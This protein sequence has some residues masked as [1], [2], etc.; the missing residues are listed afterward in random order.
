MVKT[1]LINDGGS[2]KQTT[3]TEVKNSP[4]HQA[5]VQIKKAQPV[6]KKISSKV[7]VTPNV[8]STVPQVNAVTVA[9]PQRGTPATVDTRGIQTQYSQANNGRLQAQTVSN[10]VNEQIKRKQIQ[11][12]FQKDITTWREAQEADW[13]QKRNAARNAI[14]AE[15]ELGITDP[16][17]YSEQTRSA[18]QAYQEVNAKRNPN[19]PFA[20]TQ[21]SSDDPLKGAP[22]YWAQKAIA[23]GEQAVSGIASFL[24]D[25]SHLVRRAKE[26]DELIRQGVPTGNEPVKHGNDSVTGLLEKYDEEYLKNPRGLPGLDEDAERRI[27]EFDVKSGSAASTVGDISGTIGH[28]AP[29]IFANMVIPG[30]GMGLLFMSAAGSAATEALQHGASIDKAYAYGVLSGTTEVLTEKMFE[31]VP[32]GKQYKSVEE[33]VDKVINSIAG[34][35]TARGILNYVINGVGEGAEEYLSEVVGAYTR[36]IWDEAAREEGFFETFGNVQ[37]SAIEAAY[38][39][40]LVGMFM[41]VAQ[42]TPGVSYQQDVER[43]ANALDDS[44]LMD[45]HNPNGSI[46]EQVYKMYDAALARDASIDETV[47]LLKG[48]E[49]AEE[50]QTIY[51]QL[52]DEHSAMQEMLQNLRIGDPAV[53]TSY[54]GNPILRAQIDPNTAEGALAN[55][56]TAL[57]ERFGR[58]IE[59]AESLPYE[60]N[61][62]WL[63]NTIL[64]PQRLLSDEGAVTKYLMHEMTHSAFG[65]KS[66]SQYINTANQNLKDLLGDEEYE[67]RKNETAQLYA[68]EYGG[69]RDL[70]VLMNDKE[71]MS[72]IDE[73][74]AAQYS[75]VLFN[76]PEA[77]ERLVK[78]SRTVAEKIWDTLK[79]MVRKLSG[80]EDPI[81]A[82]EV[83]AVRNAERLFASALSETRSIT[84]K[85]IKWSNLFL[86]DRISRFQRDPYWSYR[87]MTSDIED[88]EMERE[89]IASGVFD[90]TEA[91]KFIDNVNKLLDLIQKKWKEG[92]YF[93]D[94]HEEGG[95]KDRI[96]HPFKQNSD[97]LYKVSMDFSTL[98][99]KRIVTQAIIERLNLA[100][101]MALDAKTQFAIEELLRRYQKELN[102]FQ[103]A[104]ALCYVESARLKSPKVIN[105][106]IAD[107]RSAMISYYGNKHGTNQKAVVNEAQA[108]LKTWIGLDASVNKDTWADKLKGLN[109][110]QLRG[111]LSF[112]PEEKFDRIFDR[113]RPFD[114]KG[115]TTPAKMKTFWSD[116][117]EETRQ[118]LAD[119]LTE[120]QQAEVEAAEQLAKDNLEYFLTAN[121]QATLKREHPDIYD[122][123]TTKVRNA[124]KSKA[125]ET[126]V[127][128]YF[129]DTAGWATPAL[130]DK[131][132]KEN[133]LRTQS[134]SDFQLEHLLDNITA[135][136][137]LA[138][139]HAKMHGY[140]KVP[141]FVMVLGR[142]GMMINMS[143]IPEGQ[144]GFD[145]NGNLAY[146]STEGMDIGVASDLRGRYPQTAGTICIG[147]NNDQVLALMGEDNIDYIIPYHISG[148][149]AHMRAM[150]DINKWKNYQNYQFERPIKKP[151][152]AAKNA[153]DF[154]DWF[155]TEYYNDPRAS[156]DAKQIMWEAQDR[157][158][159]LCAERGLIPKFEMF[160][161]N[162]GDGTWSVPEGPDGPLNYWKLLI[163]RKMI[164][165]HEDGTSELIEQKAV[166][167]DFVWEDEVDENGNVI[168][169]LYSIVKEA[170]DPNTEETIDM[171]TNYVENA[172]AKGIVRDLSENAPGVREAI[173]MFNMTHTEEAQEE[174]DG[175][176][177]A[178][179]PQEKVLPAAMFSLPSE[180][181]NSYADIP[182]AVEG[183][184]GYHAGNLGKA[185]SRGQQG[186]YR[187]T[188]H[189][190]TGTYFVGNPQ[191]LRYGYESRPVETV[192]FSNYNLFAPQNSNDA[193]TLHE[194]LK[195]LDGGYGAREQI[196]PARIQD[197]LTR[198]NENAWGRDYGS[199]EDTI[200][201]EDGRNFDNA[202]NI[203]HDAREIMGDA[204]QDVLD[205]ASEWDGNE[206]SMDMSDF[207]LAEYPEVI[208]SILSKLD[209]DS[210]NS[211][212]RFYDDKFIVDDM[213]RR[214]ADI[215]RM[216]GVDPETVRLNARESDYD[217]NGRDPWRSDSR[218][219]QFMKN[220]GY[221]GIDTRALPDFDNTR[222]GSVIYDLKGR[223]LE[224]KN[225]NGPRFALAQDNPYSYENLIKKD[226]VKV[227]RTKSI[228]S[229]MTDGKVDRTKVINSAMLNASAVGT[230]VEE[231]N[232]QVVY[233]RN[234]YLDNNIKITNKG[235]R[236]SLRGDVSQL[237]SNIEAASQIGDMVKNGLP[238]NALIPEDDSSATMN[239][240]L[241]CPSVSEGGKYPK[242]VSITIDLYSGEIVDFESTILHSVSSRAIKNQRRE[243]KNA[244][245]IET[246]LSA[247]SISVKDFLPIVNM[248]YQSLLSNDVLSHF[249]YAKNP[250]GYYTNSAMF[251]LP[252]S[253][254]ASSI[255]STSK[256]LKKTFNSKMS[257]EEI[258]SRLNELFHSFDT[259]DFSEAEREELAGYI[260]RDIADMIPTRKAI[261][262]ESQHVLNTLKDITIR[263]TDSQKSEARHAFGDLRE[264][265]KAIAPVKM[266]NDGEMLTDAWLDWSQDSGSNGMIDTS[267]PED[268]IPSALAE[269]VG[270]LKD[271][272]EELDYDVLEEI[273][274]D[275]LEAYNNQ[276]AD[277]SDLKDPGE[278]DEFKDMYGDGE[279]IRSIDSTGIAQK[280][281]GNKRMNGFDSLFRTLDRAA[282]GDKEV[283]TWFDKMIERPM[284]EA[285][286]RYNEGRVKAYDELQ[287]IVDMYGIKAGTKESAAIQWYGEGYRVNEDG[288]RERYG[289]NKLKQE[290]PDSW[291]KIQEAEGWFRNKYDEYVDRINSVLEQIYP[292][293]E[294]K[295]QQKIASIQYNIDQLKNQAD[296]IEAH[297]NRGEYSSV[298][299][300]DTLQYVIDQIAREEKALAE[301]TKAYESGEYARNKRLVPR[302]DY[303]HHFQDVSEKG[304]GDLKNLFRGQEVLIDTNLVGISDT[305]KP[306][307][308]WMGF[309]QHQGKGE[310][311][312]DAVGGM[313][314]YMPS[315]EYAI[316]FDPAIAHMRSVVTSLR[317]STKKTRN[318]NG[319]ISYLSNFT[320]DLA[321]KTAGI[322]RAVTN[323][324][325]EVDGRATLDAIRKLNSRFKA[326]AVGA[327]VRS[328]LAQ[329]SNL[330]NGIAIVKS[331][332]AWLKGIRD[333]A[334]SIVKGGSD[335]LDQSVF[336]TERYFDGDVS[337]FEKPTLGKKISD[338]SNWMLEFGDKQAARLIW[339]SAY[340]EAMEKGLD[341]PVYY[342]DRCTQQAVAGRGV[343]EVPYNM[344]SKMVNL[345]APF[346]VE[347]NNTW[348]QLKK[349]TNERDARGMMRFMLS[350][351]VFEGM[352]ESLLGIDVIPDIFGTVV[353]TALKLIGGG[354]DDDDEEESVRAILTQGVREAIGQV[355]SAIPGASLIA[356]NIFGI[357]SDT[358]EKLFGE[359]NPSRY[360]VGLGGL[361]KLGQTAG[362]VVEA[363]ANDDKS[364]GDVDLF[365]PLV[366][367]LMP[368]GGRQLT[369]S[370]KTAQDYGVVPSNTWG[371]FPFAGGERNTLPGSY[372]SKG[373]LR[374]ELPTDDPWEMAKAFL[375]G[376][377]AT[378]AGR[379]YLENGRKTVLTQKQVEAMNEYAASGGDPHDY[380]QFIQ[381]ANTDGNSSISQA[382]AQEYLDGTNLDD[383]QKSLIWSLYGTNWKK[384]PY[385]ET[386][387]EETPSGEQAETSTTEDSTPKLTEAK[388]TKLDEYVA[389]G[390]DQQGMLDFYSGA[391]ADGNGRIKQE[392]AIEWFETS[393][394]DDVQKAL[395]WNLMWP[396]SAAKNPYD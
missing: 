110:E 22:D 339:F 58:S 391:D 138:T 238:I 191:E 186:Y 374:F 294:E 160:L 85:N 298:Y 141:E 87:S 249:G 13:N 197:V 150:A 251:S 299:S 152:E 361:A 289:L 304:I 328:A 307:S 88:G 201:T 368:F 170:E 196:D 92:G 228:E 109:E 285:H 308:R 275:I 76:D 142:T 113:H 78:T 46:K 66:F 287:D 273:T 279:G 18:I 358:G 90:V 91:E 134:W 300:N 306:K 200:F 75:Q 116:F 343:G 136:A 182:S 43:L 36:K 146:S 148:L 349:M 348:Q 352:M 190:G 99:K 237:Y 145:A 168:K 55:K 363:I 283:R 149:T 345:F 305:T 7:T 37:Q 332:S 241:L 268:S 394:L 117:T 144:T 208:N 71:F 323:F 158:L 366:E 395:I 68:E 94:L 32:L 381:G 115:I 206:F 341:D 312:A 227:V 24:Q 181:Y 64:L 153:P 19:S 313:A 376:E 264:F 248:T 155:S 118:E 217:L 123:F 392:E 384:N 314:R 387:S 140:T 245:G 73:E 17:Q 226:P 333:Y 161:N 51:D 26:E 34:N 20:K 266:R 61:G 362:D 112:I 236:H 187:G 318:A 151:K 295:Q 70:S 211:S 97:K 185:E 322:D 340:E 281:N 221:E 263:L 128:Y 114:S 334:D 324:L 57:A 56:I 28:M 156:Y 102:T 297:L 86:E 356:Q 335:I 220:M 286:R 365:G 315:A 175:D 167:P 242:I 6:A 96:Y 4:K 255:D 319:L 35:S 147:I 235:I 213:Y 214:E 184:Y 271:T 83:E 337:Q 29:D 49:A 218:A 33:A 303:F 84:S 180:K 290:F 215:A 355:V 159:E 121:G 38:M 98:C 256:K 104:C 131:M 108:S 325:G 225:A 45:A 39:G 178:G 154:S 95:K 316:A 162:N 74:L 53:I 105:Q 103:V 207:D 267:I 272:H 77:I 8:Q 259:M 329:F 120:E 342:A 205:D 371:N 100:R 219:T 370:Y 198:A 72:K 347:V 10:R 239:Y 89:L 390:H 377:Y 47:N 16:N 277:V 302:K 3:V 379:E 93:P 260:A 244:P 274:S 107:P 164:I 1:Q 60:A 126:D 224:R 194:Y 177:K 193:Y 254:P 41:G 111:A 250:D 40:A 338:A 388:Q 357:D 344:S 331:N 210:Y 80:V 234:N 350:S 31:G 204:F 23:G 216:M 230:V 172:M 258:S 320:N 385:A 253:S 336:M 262:T 369:R 326:N 265:Q 327:N 364:L 330:P 359:G 101:G 137:D 353:D 163:D 270:K 383:D 288:S 292:D 386:P 247:D 174:W 278:I 63:N 203:V 346:Q 195:A 54:Q 378:D 157:Y 125:L 15:H 183:N 52:A 280:I 59:F 129:G 127:P 311:T 389:A 179:V 122:A 354:D 360:G 240:V 188:G 14:L 301:A 166:R 269:L 309:L 233:V 133:G 257:T 373:A 396:K 2:Q 48:G 106:F 82:P 293:V 192:D 135:I 372:T 231:N 9:T 282:G 212:K 189:Y 12:N 284:Y 81:L 124:T 139:K 27:K 11:N 223:D 209:E 246:L 5:P 229:F 42:I 30:S 291:E 375:L 393:D 261:S 69:G 367:T 351:W 202:V 321:G 171:L 21:V 132:N 232:E 169:G 199:P 176:L 25:T 165:P 44:G 50:A 79:E 310:F 252:A 173:E 317:D 130:V 143:L 62:V 67:A 380:M 222:Y 296:D 382:E 276:E 65:G 119:M 243:P